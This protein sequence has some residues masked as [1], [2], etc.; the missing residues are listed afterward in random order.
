MLWVAAP[1]SFDPAGLAVVVV[2]LGVA[3]VLLAA[4]AW[5]GRKGALQPNAV[6]GIRTPRTL[7]DRQLWYQVHHA[8]APWQFAGSAVTFC[9]LLGMVLSDRFPVQVTLMVVATVALLVPC[10]VALVQVR[11]LGGPA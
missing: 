9:A 4:V 11:R 1:E 3:A 10:V 5:L 6:V 8:N 2:A 7:E